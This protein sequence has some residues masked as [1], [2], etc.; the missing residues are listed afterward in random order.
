MPPPF[1][2]G[3]QKNKKTKTATA[4]CSDSEDLERALEL[5]GM[6]V[7]GGQKMIIVQLKAL[8]YEK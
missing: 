3:T 7:G 1:M 4:I 2:K 8:E 6:E 5:S